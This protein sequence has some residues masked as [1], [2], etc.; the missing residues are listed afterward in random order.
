MIDIS[1][2]DLVERE[3]V[4]GGNEVKLVSREVVCAVDVANS[5]FGFSYKRPHRVESSGGVKTMTDHVMLLR[6][7]VLGLAIIGMTMRWFR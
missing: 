1:R 2:R 3:I 7:A 4:V 5:N 6:L